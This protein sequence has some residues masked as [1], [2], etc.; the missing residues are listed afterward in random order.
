[1]DASDKKA[2]SKYLAALADHH[3]VI[4]AAMKVKQSADSGPVQA[5]KEAVKRLHAYY[6]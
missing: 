1:M 3:S 5:L 2:Y 4:V 6:H